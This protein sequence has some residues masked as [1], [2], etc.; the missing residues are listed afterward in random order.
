M[1]GISLCPLD[2]ADPQ[3]GIDTSPFRRT[4]P[5]PQK[6][7]S[8]SGWRRNPAGVWLPTNAQETSR[9]QPSSQK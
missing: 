6:L 1:P 8:R 9:I 4:P 2:L 3:I 7:R 5:I